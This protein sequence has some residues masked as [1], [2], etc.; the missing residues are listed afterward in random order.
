MPH[1]KRRFESLEDRRL[2]AT[3]VAPGDLSPPAAAVDQAPVTTDSAPASTSPATNGTTAA[4]NSPT[5]ASS[6]ASPDSYG[7]YASAPQSGYGSSYYGSNSSY[8]YGDTYEPAANYDNT[9]GDNTATYNTP[10]N[11]TT[12]APSSSPSTPGNSATALSSNSQPTIA[13]AADAQPSPVAPSTVVVPTSP[14]AAPP[15]A[16]ASP[17]VAGSPSTAKL[18]D[19]GSAE[20]LQPVALEEAGGDQALLPPVATTNAPADWRR[21]SDVDELQETAIE[22]TA[23]AFVEM[24]LN[25]REPIARSLA[26]NSAMER[27][28]DE[29]FDRLDRLGNELAAEVGSASLAHWLVI[30]GGACAAFEYA[31]ARFR[32]GGSWQFAQGGWPMP[33]EPRLRRRWFSRRNAR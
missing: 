22:Q 9:P 21:V 29:V 26:L 13:Q 12:P 15:A 10:A 33:V 3:L 8:S 16:T 17:P 18:V 14:A 28:I 6:D 1:R 5:S 30:S 24:Q 4:A 20:L 19:Q 31:R 2:L 23:L 11:S 32:E 7:G 27:G 25:P